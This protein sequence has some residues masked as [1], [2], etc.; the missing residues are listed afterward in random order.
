MV[1]GSGPAEIARALDERRRAIGMSK[2]DLARRSGVSLPNVQRILAAQVSPTWESLSRIIA[3]LG[4]ALEISFRDEEDFRRA[5]A[6]E[7]AERIARLVQGNMALEEQGVDEASYQRMVRKTTDEL[8]VGAQ[9]RLWS[10]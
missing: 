6:R 7:K 5:A 9:R 1:P 10:K 3:A 4:G 2:A 8:L